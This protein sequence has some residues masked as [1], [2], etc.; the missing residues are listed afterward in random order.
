MLIAREK[1]K[2]NI[3]EYILYMWQVEDLLRAMAFDMQRVKETVINRFQVDEVR[4][5]EMYD[6]YDNLVEMM[7]KEKVEEKGHLQVLRNNVDELTEL[8]F[9]LLQKAGD[10]RYRQIVLMASGNLVDFRTKSG[11]GA[12]VSDVELALTALYGQLML[13]LQKKE[14]NSQT[15]VA[16]ESF[17]K[18]IGYLAAVYRKN[19]SE[20]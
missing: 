14:I 2:S 11:A 6:W 17:S 12:E 9:F 10:M 18:M 19:E 20:V 3:A 15:V 8:H 13:R 1:K 16:M 4:A 7:K 5:K